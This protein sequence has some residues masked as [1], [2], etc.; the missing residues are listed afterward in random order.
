MRRV[1]PA[2]LSTALALTLAGCGSAAS[3]GGGTEQAARAAQSP[4][5]RPA[6]ITVEANNG[7]VEVPTDPQRVVALDNSS[8]ETLKAFGITPVAAPK[9]LLPENLKEWAD[10]GDI[11]DVGTHREPKLEVVAQAQPDLIV[12]GKRFQKVTAN[13]QKVAPVIDLAPSTE[14][15]GYVDAL[16]KQTRTLG[17]IFGKQAEANKLVADLDAAVAAA[18]EKSNGQTAF[19]ANHNGGKID[20]GAGR[21]GV[22][23]QPLKVTDVFGTAANNESVHQDSGLAPETVAQKNPDLMIVMDRD[24]AVSSTRDTATPASQ[25]VAAQ[26]AWSDT[27]FMKKD[28]IVY[29]ADN[30]YV[31][32]G[33]QAYTDAYTKIADALGASAGATS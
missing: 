1:A 22:L 27:T 5:A 24:A 19:L 25:T 18:A 11:L 33:I 10:N 20:N 30:F 15:A 13:L 7:K 9:Q 8:F 21:I 2:V 14:K 6:T 32:E 29:L 26:K 31:T 12:G 28:A 23:L 16:K 17:E 3:G 4:S